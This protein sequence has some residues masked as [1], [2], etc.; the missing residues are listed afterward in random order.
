MGLSGDHFCAPNHQNYFNFKNLSDLLVIHGFNVENYWIDN[1]SQFSLY[2]FLKRFLIKR[3]QVTAFPPVKVTLKTIWKW[4]K[5]SHK[6]V[7]VS[8]YEDKHL[9]WMNSGTFDQNEKISLKKQVKKILSS[10]IP[11]R[12]KTHQT[13]LA[14]YNGEI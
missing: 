8:S 11:L 3:E 1:R 2:A 4:Q 5:N 6:S 9:S 7:I 13:I 10:L 12:F 14:K